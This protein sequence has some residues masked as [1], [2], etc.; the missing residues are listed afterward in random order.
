[1]YFMVCEGVAVYRSTFE[2]L[3]VSWQ[4]V[5]LR[6]FWVKLGMW[7]LDIEVVEDRPMRA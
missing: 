3:S 7:H 2:I 6:V 1:M 5:E 4:V